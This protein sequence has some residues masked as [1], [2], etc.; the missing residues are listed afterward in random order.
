M[1]SFASEQGNLTGDV[2]SMLVA[3]VWQVNFL[4][5][6]LHVQVNLPDACDEHTVYSSGHK[7]CPISDTSLFPQ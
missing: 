3:S 6:Q 5:V 7:S 2:D 1:E 4:W